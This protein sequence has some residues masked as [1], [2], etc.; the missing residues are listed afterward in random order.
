MPKTI[1]ETYEVHGD[2]A[3]G[4]FVYKVTGIPGLKPFIGTSHFAKTA[5]QAVKVVLKE[6]ERHCKGYNYEEGL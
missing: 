4:W 6:H 1:T 2:R 3:T 5:K